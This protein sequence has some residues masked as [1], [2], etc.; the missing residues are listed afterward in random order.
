MRGHHDQVAVALARRLDD[1][2]GRIAVQHMHRIGGNA[3]FGRLGQQ[4]GHGVFHGSAQARQLS[5]IACSGPLFA[6]WPLMMM[7]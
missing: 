4:V 7:I 3:L 1:A 2:V 5:A 6:P